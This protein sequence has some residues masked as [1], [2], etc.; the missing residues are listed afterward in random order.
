VAVNVAGLDDN[1]FSDS[2]FGH[3]KGA[4]T[5]AT[6]SRKGFL[7]QASGG[8]ILLDEIGDLTAV[9]QVKLLRLLETREFYPLGSDLAMISN[10]RIVVATN[11][12]LREAVGSG[13][14]RKDLYYRLSAHEVRLPA[15]RER[16][17]DLPLLLEHFM[18]EASQRLSKKKL[19]VPSELIPFLET[20][21]FPGNIRELRSMIFDAVSR[22]SEKMLSL[23]SFREAMGRDAQMVSAQQQDELVVFKE[24]LPTLSQVQELLIEEAMKRA[25]GVKS[26]AAMLLGVTPQALGK[27][28]GRKGETKV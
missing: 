6:E 27:R 10:A 16:K 28:L 4:Y 23:K 19:A 2:L 13:E 8:T 25:K 3:K 15:L 18:E 7:Q 11:K 21:D 1:M 20:Y 26:T 24:R 9:S 22:Q 5:G 17:G 12:N 14:F